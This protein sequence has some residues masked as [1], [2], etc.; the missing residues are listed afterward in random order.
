MWGIIP[1]K[2]FCKEQNLT[3]NQV[4]AS[5]ISSNWFNRIFLGSCLAKTGKFQVFPSF[6]LREKQ[7]T[8]T[9]QEEGTEVTKGLTDHGRRKRLG[10]LKDH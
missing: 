7:S 2:H 9:K 3:S 1:L 4:G 10:A 6:R 5:I 8:D